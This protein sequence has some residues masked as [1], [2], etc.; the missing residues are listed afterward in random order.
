[1]G[2]CRAGTQAL[3]LLPADQLPPRPGALFPRRGGSRGADGQ[4]AQPEPGGPPGEAGGD[5]LLAAGAG[6]R[7]EGPLRR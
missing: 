2:G 1:M 4:R 7:R 5:L 6:G 3:M